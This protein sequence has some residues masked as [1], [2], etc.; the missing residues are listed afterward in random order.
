M[1]F[2]ETTKLI[3]HVLFTGIIRPLFLVAIIWGMVAASRHTPPVKVMLFKISTTANLASETEQIPPTISGRKAEH[4][5][6][7]FIV[8]TASQYQIDPALIK[9]I[10]MAESGYNSKAVSKS[11][12]KGLMQLMPETAEALGVEDIF[13][14]RQN[15]SG[16]VQ[17][18]KHLVNRFSGDV[19]LALAAYNAGSRYVRNYNGVPPFKATRHYIKQVFKYYRQYKR[20]TSGETDR[21]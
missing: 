19:E 4:L 18:F 14:P 17:Y 9:A 3:V 8:Q 6:H 16:G 21:A 1:K 10:I 2:K 15:I 7:K 20:Q 13:N 12:A 11:G 5:Y